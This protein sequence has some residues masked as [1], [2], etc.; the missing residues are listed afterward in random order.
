M[1]LFRIEGG[2]PLRGRVPIQGSK[3]AVLPMMAA[4]LLQKGTVCFHHCP[5]I[6]DVKCM[7]EILK[8]AGAVSWRQK[9]SLWIDCSQVHTEEI[10]GAYGEKMRSSVFFMGSLLSR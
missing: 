6:S 8:V 2:V 1:D 9:D 10:P 3:N 5:A 4:A 7:E